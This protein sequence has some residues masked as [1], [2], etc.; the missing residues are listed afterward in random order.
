MRLPPVARSCSA[1]S[2]F[3]F[4]VKCGLVPH[5]GLRNL[6]APGYTTVPGHGNSATFEICNVDSI[7]RTGPGPCSGD[8]QDLHP[9]NSV[10]KS[11]YRFRGP[12][13]SFTVTSQTQHHRC[14]KRSSK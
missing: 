13:R 7:A 4:T 10:G 14:A 3:A 12:A 6:V 2:W 1:C 8:L 11:A 9:V 5:L